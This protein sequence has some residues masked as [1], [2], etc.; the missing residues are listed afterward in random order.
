M[1][2]ND[3]DSCMADPGTVLVRGLQVKFPVI[4]YPSQKCIASHVFIEL[5]FFYKYFPN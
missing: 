5:C 3:Q 1:P 4:P 2:Q